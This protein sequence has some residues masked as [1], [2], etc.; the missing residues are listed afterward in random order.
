MKNTILL[1]TWEVANELAMTY[2]E[3]NG[4]IY[5]DDTLPDMV[6]D[7]CDDFNIEITD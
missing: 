7:F 3:E 1:A 2:F 6:N 4:I 5:T